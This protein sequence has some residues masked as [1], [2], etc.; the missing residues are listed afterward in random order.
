MFWLCEEESAEAF[1]DAFIVGVSFF[2]EISCTCASVWQV[3]AGIDG[4]YEVMIFGPLCECFWGAI[5][6]ADGIGFEVEEL[7][8]EAQSDDMFFF[9]ICEWECCDIEALFFL[10]PYLW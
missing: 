9:I 10:C 4:G 1:D 8:V 6:F 3:H 5:I 7:R 2:T